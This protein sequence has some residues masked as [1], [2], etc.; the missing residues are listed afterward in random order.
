MDIRI[1]TIT[2]KKAEAYLN[3][4]R[5]N[6]KLRDGVVERYADDMAKGRWTR[7][8]APICFYDDGDVADGQHRLWAIVESGVPQ[9]FPV[10]RGFT[11]EDGLNIDTGLNRSIIDNAKISGA[12]TNL[13]RQLLTTARAITE[14]AHSSGSKSNSAKLAQLDDHRD[15]SMWASSNVR[16]FRY[17]CSAPVLGAVGRAWYAETDKV[18]LK[19]FCTVLA[20]G[21]MTDQSESSA[22]ALRNY[23]IS[24][25]NVAST[26]AQWTDTFLKVQNAINYFMRGKPLTVI[27]GV[28]EEAYPLPKK[29]AAVKA[30]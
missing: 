20:D 3:T 15:A 16:R 30:K 17:L 26:S 2:P 29:R 28:K 19:R 6:R 11:R 24:R 22:V 27:K 13:S 12:D 14:G 21:F 4:N 1:E 18:R 8:P 10:A 7:C 9:S 5:S 25:G 23:L